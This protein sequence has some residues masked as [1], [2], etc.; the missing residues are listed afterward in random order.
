MDRMLYVAMSGAKQT[1]LSQGANYNNMANASTD[2]FRADLAALSSKPIYGPGAATRVNSVMENVGID[3]TIGT[4]SRTGRELDIALKDEGWVAA[5]APDGSE[6]YTRTGNLR[7]G[8]GGILKNA[9]GL[10]ILGS[11]GPIAIPPSEK[12]E[13][14]SDGTISIRGLGQTPNALTILDRIKLVKIDGGSLGK[15]ADG[16]LRLRDGATAV[17]DATITV[18]AGALES[19]NVNSVEAMANMIS[20]ARLYEAQVKIMKTAEETDNSATQLLSL[21]S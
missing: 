20:M 19:S 15:G 8:E 3:T 9:A 1:M 11:G 14:G 18:I 5:Q 6:V 7:I 21:G 4:I 17:P 16:L 13:I 10:T 12:I 2:G